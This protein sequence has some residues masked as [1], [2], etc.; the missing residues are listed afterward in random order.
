M[1]TSA[2][3]LSFVSHL[4]PFGD[5]LA[6]IEGVERIVLTCVKTGTTLGIIDFGPDFHATCLCWATN[7]RLIVGNNSGEVVQADLMHPITPDS[8]KLAE[9]SLITR[10]HNCPVK[11]LCFDV[12]SYLL[13]ASFDG[14]I[15]I[16]YGH[17]LHGSRREWVLYDTL[18]CQHDRVGWSASAMAFLSTNDK[19]LF[20]A[21][22]FGFAVWVFS[23]KSLS[24][25]ERANS[26]VIEHCAVSLDSRMLAASTRNFCVLMWPLSA[27]GPISKRQRTFKIPLPTGR[28]WISKANSSPVSFLDANSIVTADPAG[29]V[30]IVSLDGQVQRTFSVGDNY[31]VKS[32]W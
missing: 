5:L 1:M 30:Y 19:S 4:S 17:L 15:K 8:L 21:T 25:Y 24:W 9:L 6:S 20:A 2:Q 23:D 26:H 11:I 32:I 27:S 22:E 13:A 16:W 10:N 28:D 3:S 12:S 7:T 18:L 31:L 14:E 29:T